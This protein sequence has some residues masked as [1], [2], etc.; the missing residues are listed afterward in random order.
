MKIL[1]DFHGMTQIVREP[2][3]GNYLLDLVLCDIAGVKAHVMPRIADHNALRIDVPFPAVKECAVKRVVWCL[4]DANW[5]SLQK[6]LKEVDWSELA[7]GTAEDSVNL[8]LA[9]LWSLLIKHTP[10]K[11]ITNKQSTHPWLNDRCRQAIVNKNDAE[12]S[13]SFQ[14][15]QEMCDEVLRQ[16]RAKYTEALKAKLVTLPKSSKQWWRINRE[17]LNRKATLMTVPPLRDEG[18]WILEAKLKADTFAKTF[19]A[20]CQLVPETVDT[21]FFHEPDVEM[22]DFVAMRTRFTRRLLEKLDVSKATGHDRISAAILKRL[23]ECLAMPFTRV[24]RR[25]YEEGCWPA[26]WKLHLIVPIYKRGSAFNASNYRGV[27]LTS[28]LSKIAEKVIS[29]RL[30]PFLQSTAFGENQWGFSTGLSSKD[31]VTMLVMSW[32]LAVCMNC[33][34]GGYLSDISGAFDR[35]F[36]RYMIAKLYVAGVGAKYLNFLEAY[37]APRR[38]RVVVQGASSDDFVLDDMLFQGTVLGPCLWNTFFADVGIPARSTGGQEAMF[39]DDLNMFQAFDLS[40]PLP[41]VISKL[42]TCRQRV[43]KWGGANRVSFDAAK[44]HLVVIH[45]REHHG[46]SFK[47]LGCMIDVDLKMCTALEQLL[48]KI[49]AKSIAILRMRAYY[50]VPELVNQYKCHVWGLVECHCGAYFH[51]SATLLDRVAQVQR[52]FLHKLEISESTAFLEFNFAPTELRRNIAILGLLHKRVL[53]QAHKAFERLLPFY[54]QR[55]EEPRGFGHNKQLYGHWFEVTR[56]PSLYCKSIFRMV[57][58]F[59]NLPQHVVDSKCV[60]TFQRFL[61]EIAKKRCREGESL[62]HKSFSARRVIEPQIYD[63]E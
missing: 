36:V 21:P 18:T 57:D 23:G 46:D 53:G 39:A 27:H 11:E 26:V 6:E 60:T 30:T 63:D 10:R 37:L 52:S 44:E 29:V 55:F 59:N 61:T 8:F 25:L 33:K 28:I 58:I 13:D 4:S 40:T 9:I 50:S 12:G 47:L 17:L 35:V 24:C 54:S 49:R 3:R 56:Y 32:I 45:P 31:L 43:H 62:W 2:T 1:C 15:K 19:A 16:E 48:S 41:D 7:R 38:G 22:M 51:A 42:T 34:V 20:K 14:A 5:K